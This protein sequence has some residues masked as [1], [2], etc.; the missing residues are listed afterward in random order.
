M[1]F[2]YQRQVSENY[3]LLLSL[4]EEVYPAGR[5]K[6]NE[7]NLKIRKSLK[8]MEKIHG[9][10]DIAPFFVAFSIHVFVNLLS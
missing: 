3:Q 7:K 10:E 6:M 8:W 9:D 1:E 4:G 2:S 5:S